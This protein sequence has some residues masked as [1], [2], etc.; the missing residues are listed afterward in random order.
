MLMGD[1]NSLLHS[2]RLCTRGRT[3]CSRLSSVICSQRSTAPSQC[4]IQGISLSLAIW[5]R[6]IRC[7]L[8]TGASTSTCL[9]PICLE[10]LLT[11]LT[12][13]LQT[14]N[15]ASLTGFWESVLRNEI[16]NDYIDGDVN[17]LHGWRRMKARGSICGKSWMDERNCMT[18]SPRARARTS[19]KTC[20]Q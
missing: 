12:L 6:I 2:E 1:F 17:Y 10:S 16:I 18:F 4:H 11:Q 13:C 15:E 14:W 8:W 19:Q 5:S 7:A 20:A 3:L 9:P